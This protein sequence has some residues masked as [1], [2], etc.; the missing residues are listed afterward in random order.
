VS[1]A[2]QTPH[3][4]VED[5]I[6][7]NDL[8]GLDEVH[9]HICGDCRLAWVGGMD[10][11]ELGLDLEI[12]STFSD[13]ARAFAESTRHISCADEEDPR[14]G[15]FDCLICDVTSIGGFKTVAYMVP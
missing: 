14:H 2:E 5:P 12:S 13:G 10:E 3:P 7:L 15:Y 6:P 11:R 4:Q 8:E 1:A 9:G